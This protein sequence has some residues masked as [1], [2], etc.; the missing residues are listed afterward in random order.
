MRKRVTFELES[1]SKSLSE[2]ESPH[3]VTLMKSRG[4]GPAWARAGTS[5]AAA[6]ARASAAS[7]VASRRPRRD[8][9]SVRADG[10]KALALPIV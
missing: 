4:G 5:D 1:R 6:S 3:A 9:P 2:I 8:E 10:A 7:M